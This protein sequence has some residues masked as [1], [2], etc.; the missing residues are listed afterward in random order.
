MCPYAEGPCPQLVFDRAVKMPAASGLPKGDGVGP[1]PLDL[2]RVGDII[3]AM[4][5]VWDRGWGWGGLADKI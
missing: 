2:C 4:T 5:L 1:E 3:I